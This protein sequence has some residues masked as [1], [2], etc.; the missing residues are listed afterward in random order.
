MSSE[1][2]EAF[3]SAP[4]P[5]VCWLQTV[6][7]TVGCKQPLLHKLI[8]FFSHLLTAK[9]WNALPALICASDCKNVID[10]QVD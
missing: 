8:G 3:Q 1:T 7:S 4:T 9:V 5:S 6:A 2:V 10:T